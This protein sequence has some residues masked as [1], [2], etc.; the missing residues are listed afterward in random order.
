MQKNKL[1]FLYTNIG[2]GHPFYLDGIV[3]LAGESE[4]FELSISDVFESSS[5]ISCLSWQLA[6][7]LYK[8]GSA[9]SLVGRIYNK[10]RDSGD[11][12]RQGLAMRIMGRDI[13]KK[14][15]GDSAPLIVAHP[16][17]VGML[18]GRKNLL[19]QHG[20]LAV[21]KQAI[22]TGAE[23]VFVPTE[24]AAEPFISS[25]YSS[26]NVI[27]TG[28]CI[29]PCIV[30]QAET[31]FKKRMSRLDSSDFL[32]G[33]FF[34]SGA[35]PKP[36]IEKLVMAAV[37][38]VE[39]SHKV[40]MFAK[41]DGDLAS[42]IKREFENRN[43]EL[44]VVDDK[45]QEVESGSSAVL[46]VYADRK[47]ETELVCRFFDKLDF[48]VAPSHERSNWAMGLGLPM[49]ILEPAIGPFSPL[50]REILLEAGVAESMNSA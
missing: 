11:Y 6:R 21:P 37:S 35:E 22:V 13:E 28:L 34:S 14:Y 48:F 26:S 49:F 15:H 42:M 24:K 20:E 3:E 32:T 44:I 8:I 19:Y 12:S 17:L 4:K 30:E 5:D 47:T 40:I 50:N 9:D 27:V 25:G 41:K 10:L 36:H 43:T 38:I 7:A 39:Q 18:S 23:Y 16:I 1:N 31:A 2:R 29:E 33:A 46:C 45:S